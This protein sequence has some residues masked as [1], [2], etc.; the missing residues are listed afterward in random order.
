MCCKPAELLHQVL[1]KAH[2][3]LLY[4]TDESRFFLLDTG[5]SNG[6]FVNNIRLSKS[7]SESELTE[8]FTGDILRFG[9]DV[10]DKSRN[11][12]QKSVIMKIRLVLPDGRDHCPRPSS[13]RLYRPSDSYEDLSIVTTNLQVRG[14]GQTCRELTLISLQTA[15]SR[16]KFL[17]DKLLMFKSILTK[18]SEDTDSS[19]LINDLQ[20]ALKVNK[21]QE[22]LPVKSATPCSGGRYWTD[23]I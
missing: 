10:L 4:E 7:G 18:H 15:L 21:W 20:F 22:S 5:S 1:S 6:T 3:L 13:S 2:A 9:S 11:V 19:S 23:H 17:E 14:E 16:E 8:V 12:T